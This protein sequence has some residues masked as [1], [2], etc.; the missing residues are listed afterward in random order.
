MTALACAR[1]ALL[2]PMTDRVVV[3]VSDQAHSS[4]AR[5]A[6]GCSASAR[7]RCACC[8]TDE[9]LAHAA[10]RARG[11]DRRRRRRRPPAAVRG[12]RGGLDQH[13]R[14]R[15]ARRARRVCREH[16]VWL[17][18]D[19]AY[20]GFAALTERGRAALRG[21]ELADSVTLD[22]HKWLYQPFECGCAAGARGPPAAAQAF[23]I[24]P[25]YL[26]GRGRSTRA[27]S[28][29]PT[30]GLQ[31]T[32]VVPRA[33][34]LAVDQ[35]LRRRRVPRRDRPLARPRRSSPRRASR[36]TPEL[37]LMSPGV[38]RASS[39]SAAG[40]AATRTRRPRQLNGARRGLEATGRGLVSS[41]RLRGR[42]AIRLCVLNHTTTAADV[43]RVLDWFADGR[44]PRRRPSPTAP[45]PAFASRRR[46]PGWLGDAER[47]VRGAAGGAAV[48]RARARTSSARREL[49]AR[50]AGRAGRGSSIRAG[51][52]RATSTS[53]STATA[54]VERDGVRLA[55]L[56][57][58][59]LLRRARR[60]RLGRGLR[61]PP[62]GHGDRSGADA[63][64]DR[65]RTR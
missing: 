40:S 57:A 47:R 50:A 62:H 33:E 58:G 60:A 65:R 1:E 38:A 35:S 59:R 55:E 28:T 2:G 22:P 64:A 16:G 6:R 25:D 9:R 4:I 52:P 26:Q 34:G 53:C 61:L 19:G 3:Y 41:T 49:G 15:P 46:P 12:R 43:E 51:M 24:A 13:R 44:R 23:E 37:E 14:G 63:T 36:A 31:L 32:R 39:A 29:S 30:C 21:I 54:E 11:R 10:G 27:R 20:G 48:R 42:Y 45:Q 17:H 8:P 18:V 7:T 5:A 56:G